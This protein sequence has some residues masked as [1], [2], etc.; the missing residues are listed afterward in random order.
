VGPNPHG[1]VLDPC[2]YRP[3]LRVRS[4][5]STGA[6]RTPRMGSGPL[7][8]VRATHSRVP[9]FWDKEYPGLNQGQAGVQGQHVSGPYRIRFRS[10]P[11]RRPD[12]ATWPTARDVSQRAEPNLRPLGRMASAFIADKAR[13]LSIPLAGDVSPRHLMSPVHSTGRRCAVSA[14]NEPC[15][16]HWHVVT[17]PSRRRRACPF[18]WQAHPYCRMHY[19]HH[20]SRVT[21]EAAATYQYCMDYRHYG[22]WSSPRRYRH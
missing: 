5:T 14:F 6:N 3:D 21:E 11:R 13:R 12:A 20:D 15:P 17:R 9:G 18:H 8:G 1:K 2:I 4:R 16:L 10:P 22:A 7:C 19:T